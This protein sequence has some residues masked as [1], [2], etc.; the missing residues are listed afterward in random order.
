MDMRFGTWNVKSLY[1]EGSMVTAL[2]ELSKYKLDLVGV[3]EVNGMAVAPNQKE[4]THFL[5]KREWQS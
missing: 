5:R 2:K 3:Q 4:N 1:W